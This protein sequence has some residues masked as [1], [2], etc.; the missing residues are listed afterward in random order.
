MQSLGLQINS[1]KQISKPRVR[2][3]GRDGMPLKFPD[4]E[5]GASSALLEVEKRAAVNHDGLWRIDE[6]AYGIVGTFGFDNANELTGITYVSGSTQVGTL[7]YGY[8]LGWS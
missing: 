7:T 8:E 3:L 6:G 4:T 2:L 1:V 5:F